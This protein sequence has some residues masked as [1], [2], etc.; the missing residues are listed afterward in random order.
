M[1]PAICEC[2]ADYRIEE[3]KPDKDS[4]VI[5]FLDSL[6]SKLPGVSLYYYP[7]FR[8]MLARLGTGIPYY[9]GAFSED[10]ELVGLLPAFYRATNVGTVLSSL[11][12]CGTAGVL[13]HT[14]AR[15]AAVHSALIAELTKRASAFEDILTC[16]IYT[17]FLFENFELYESATA[18]A[19]MVER[20]T[21]FQDIQAGS[22]GKDRLYDIRKAMRSGIE[23]STERTSGNLSQFYSLYEQ[24]CK[25]VGIPLKPRACV[26][27][28]AANTDQVGMYF[29]FCKG[30]IVGGLLMLWTGITAIYYIPCSLADARHLEPGVLLIARAMEDARARGVRFWNWEG[31]PSRDSGV[32]RFKKKWGGQEKPYRIYV[33]AFRDKDY[34]R[35]IGA[36]K[37]GAAF[38]SYFVYP[39]ASLAMNSPAS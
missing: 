26:E 9:L 11:P 14:G 30:E 37:L 1:L 18:H 6:G 12:F 35:A 32:Y 21:Q 33:Q 8:D 10:D 31:S 38:P 39:F 7:F 17:P 19:I 27:Y 22:L 23:V 3:L 15:A 36:Q 16:S 13:C 25:D 24:N 5:A 20:F 2:P 4:R 29:A 34:M 28:L